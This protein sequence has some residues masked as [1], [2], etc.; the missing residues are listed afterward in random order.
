MNFL[1][2]E[3]SEEYKISDHTN[4]FRFLARLKHRSISALILVSKT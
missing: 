2:F 1:N 3:K 4:N